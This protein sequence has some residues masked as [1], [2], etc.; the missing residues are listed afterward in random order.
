MTYDNTDAVWTFGVYYGNE[1]PM[2]ERRGELIFR[3]SNYYG[4]DMPF[5]WWRKTEVDRFFEFALWRL[6]NDAAG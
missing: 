6:Q 3:Q 2:I 1:Y 4:D 5:E